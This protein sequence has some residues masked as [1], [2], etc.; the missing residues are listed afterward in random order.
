VSTAGAFVF[1]D[2]LAALATCRELGRAGIPVTVLS[3]RPGPAA[4]SRFARFVQV[5]DFYRDADA[6]AD[7]VTELADRCDQTPVLLPTEDAALLVADRYH[8]RLS[9]RLRYPCPAPG[10][11]E[12]IVDKRRLYEAATRCGLFAPRCIDPADDGLPTELPAD[13]EWLAKPPCRYVLDGNEVRTFLSITGG[14]KAL[15]GDVVGAAARVRAAGFPVMVQ[16]KIPGPFEE[17]VSVG[18]AIDR[19]GEVRAAFTARKA[20]EY[21]EPFGD[22]LLVE[23]IDDPD[24][25]LIDMAARLLRETGYWGICDVEF[26]RDPRD[27]RF[28]LLDANPRVWLWLQLGAAA[29]AP[30]ALWAHALACAEPAPAQAPATGRNRGRYPVW[31]SPRGFAAFMATS[32]RPGRHGLRLPL[33][34]TLGALR[35]ILGNLAEF[36]DPL[37]LRP[38]AWRDIAQAVARRSGLRPPVPARG[39]ADG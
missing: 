27:G 13:T 36:H 1:P 39:S 20:C 28:K 7:A 12:K 8:T 14:S 33:R 25:G 16:E 32:Y 31:V 35:T 26:K 38:S 21:P 2:N 5:P 34:L 24:P 15:D 30:M 10:T 4:Y 9:P 19:T 37:Y 3:A 11:L 18:I 6:W 23:N 29:G 17:L 22:G